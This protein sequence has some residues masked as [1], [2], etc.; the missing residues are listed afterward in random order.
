MERNSFISEE[1][2]INKIY[3]IRQQKVMLDADLAELY[4]VETRVL[5]QAVRRNESRF[6]DDFMFELTSEENVNLRIIT[7]TMSRGKHP[8][9]LP[10]V[11]T[12]QGVA[13]LSTIL[14]SESAIKVNI[15]IMRIF[16]RI[17]QT[18]SDNTE[19]RLEIEKIKRHVDNHDKNIELVFHYLDELLEKNEKPAQPRK[20]LGYKPD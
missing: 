6:P 11:F 5:K 13:M 12:E 8:K 10:Y 3:Y 2:I 14:N 9:Y 17:R 4:G 15:Q 16:T 20:R 18:L 19:L 7:G 1:I